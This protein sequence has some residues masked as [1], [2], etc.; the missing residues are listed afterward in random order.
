MSTFTR[1]DTIFQDTCRFSTYFF[2]DHPAGTMYVGMYLL[3]AS[4]FLRNPGPAPEWHHT[5][6]DGPSIKHSIHITARHQARENILLALGCSFRAQLELS[7]S[8]SGHAKALPGPIL[9][10]TPGSWAQT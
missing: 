7:S 9:D 5:K 10:Q 6:L 4:K 2:Q 1:C 8:R 3:E